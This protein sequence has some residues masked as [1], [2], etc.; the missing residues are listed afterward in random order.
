LTRHQEQST[1][2]RL[3]YLFKHWASIQMMRKRF[4][5]ASAWLDLDIIWWIYREAAKNNASA[6]IKDP[7]Q[8]PHIL[9]CDHCSIKPMAGFRY[10]C[11]SCF[12]FPW[13]DLCSACVD[14][15]SGI[16]A[17]PHVDFVKIPSSF[18]LP[19]LDQQLD[20]LRH[21]LENDL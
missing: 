4:K 12:T 2:L 11:T 3:S 10:R 9:R 19:T 1:H 8:I 17:H 5:A 6:E 21:A 20:I 16:M 13:F 15:Q 7:T 14:K 18:P